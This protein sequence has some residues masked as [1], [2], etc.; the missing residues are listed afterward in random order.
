MVPRRCLSHM[1]SGN[2]SSMRWVG[3]PMLPKPSECTG[4]PL[5]G[6]GVGWVPDEIVEDSDTMILMQNPGDDEEREG[7]PAVGKTGQVMDAKMLPRAGLIRG[8][9]TVANVL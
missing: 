1:P 4:C 7:R 8:Q 9:V 2:A 5:Y 3:P 6:D